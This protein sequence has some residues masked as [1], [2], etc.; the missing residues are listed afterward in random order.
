MSIRIISKNSIIK[1]SISLFLV[2]A[3]LAAKPVYSEGLCKTL[4][5]YFTYSYVSWGRSPFDKI[6]L[7]MNY[8]KK[9]SKKSGS[10]IFKALAPQDKAKVESDISD[11]ETLFFSGLGNQES[12]QR[13]KENIVESLMSDQGTQLNQNFHNELAFYDL[14]TNQYVGFVAANFYPETLT[15]QISY[16]VTES[17]R[18]KNYATDAVIAFTKEI[19]KL[20]PKNYKLRATTFTNNQASKRVLEKANFKLVNSSSQ[21]GRNVETFELFF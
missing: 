3:L 13:A 17:A 2:L 14:K 4:L 5:A 11:S 12:Q 16:L 9:T 1:Q 8:L 18:G 6:S 21:N 15:V 7:Q 20:L 19:K 10:L